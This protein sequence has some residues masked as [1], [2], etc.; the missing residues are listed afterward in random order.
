[1]RAMF[2]RTNAIYEPGAVKRNICNL[3][4]LH[5]ISTSKYYEGEKTSTVEREYSK[6]KK[7]IRNW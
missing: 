3:D 5:D 1:M 4:D 6:T 7:I 2:L